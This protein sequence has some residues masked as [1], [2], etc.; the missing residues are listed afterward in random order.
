MKKVK[1]HPLIIVALFINTLANGLSAYRHYDDNR[2]GAI[3]FIV[4]CFF[5]LTLAV[6][7]IFRNRKINE[8]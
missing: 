8:G 3:F 7:G 5:T 2:S 4:L 6:Y 1:I